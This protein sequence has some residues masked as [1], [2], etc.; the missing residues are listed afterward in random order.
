MV[1]RYVCLI[2]RNEIAHP[3]AECPYCQSRAMIAEGA[4]PRVIAIVF[5]VMA[6]IF[7]LAGLYTRAFNQERRERGELHFQAAQLRLEEQEYEEAIAHYRDALLYSRDNADYQLGLARALYASGRYSETEHYLIELRAADPTS[8]IVNRLLARLAARAGRVDEA[9]SYYRTASYGQW[10]DE[11]E[12]TRLH[13]RLELVDLLEATER[14]QQLTAELLELLEIIPDDQ[15]IRHR[16]AS[17]LLKNGV[18]DRASTLFAEL[19]AADGRDR[20]ALLG[21]AEA[22]FNLG[23]YLTA[24]TH[25]NRAQ[26]RSP[27]DATAERIDLCNRIIALDPT[28]R[29]IGLAERFRRSRVLLERARAALEACRNPQ[30]A[31][32]AGPLPPLQPEQA[33]ALDRVEARI[34]ETAR[35]RASDER[36]EANIQ[37]AEDLWQASA[38]LCRPPSQPDAPLLH[39]MAKLSR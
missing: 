29:G 6:A 11:T 35:R 14:E 36:V 18:Y 28:R 15:A 33:D 21:R 20:A 17:L 22:E 12:Q 39:V 3:G 19:V 31:S 16:L 38:P 2:C 1:K 23:N 30:G 32:F 10:E 9:V 5:G 25:Y 27:D 26:L 37:A 8:G 34:R 7:V 13:L 24:R 4:S